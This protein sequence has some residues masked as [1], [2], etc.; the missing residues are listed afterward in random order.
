[1]S[2]PLPQ[3][4]NTFGQ[5]LLHRYGRRVHK[6][7]INAGFTCPNRDGSKGRGGCSFCNNVSFS[8]HARREPS[9]SEQID[10]GRAVI[11][12][13]TGAQRFIA[14]FQAYTNT[15]ADVT[16]LDRLYREALQATDVIGLSIG[17][18]PDCVPPAVLDLLAG[19]QAEGREVWLELGL[20]SAFDDTLALVNR[21]HYFSEYID[22]VH[23]AR[24]RGLKVCTH[25]I[26]GLPGEGPQHAKTTLARV[27]ELGVDG[28]KLHPLHVVKG[29]LLANQWRRGGYRPWALDDYLETAADLVELTPPHIVYHRL[30]G[31]AS[32]R[33]LLAPEWCRH[34]WRVIDGIAETLARRGTCQGSALTQQ[35]CMGGL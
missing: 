4:V 15:Y 25:L 30:T 17:T 3:L 35:P 1:M 32:P 16:Q 9:V 24:A 14:Y 2:S 28:L 27:L 22:A 23:E 6:I 29:T 34:K 12:K 33:I 5:D 13:R 18:R 19:Y 21:G 31:T 10:A 8:P 20:Q 11:R 26:V 7:A